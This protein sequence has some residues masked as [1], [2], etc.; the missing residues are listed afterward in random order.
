MSLT[1]SP[2]ERLREQRRAFEIHFADV[3]GERPEVD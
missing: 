3:R 2:L 1:Y